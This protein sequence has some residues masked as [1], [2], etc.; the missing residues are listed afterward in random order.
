[1][2]ASRT[3]NFSEPYSI[4]CPC[5]ALNCTVSVISISLSRRQKYCRVISCVS[6]LLASFSFW[7]WKIHVRKWYLP[8]EGFLETSR[9]NWVRLNAN[10]HC[11]SEGKFWKFCCELS[12]VKR[13]KR[14]PEGSMCKISS[15][16]D[17][18][19]W[20]LISL[21]FLNLDFYYAWMKLGFNFYKILLKTWN[22]NFVVSISTQEP[23]V[24]N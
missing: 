8:L 4:T 12:V 20:M 5:F 24:R 13:I 19:L 23:C 1:M 3:D 21:I 10:I 7:N 16:S 6:H 2:W 18:F 17:E 15:L 11:V 9:D 14:I 22:I